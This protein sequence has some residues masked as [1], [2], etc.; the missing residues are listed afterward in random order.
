MNSAEARCLTSVQWCTAVVVLRCSLHASHNRKQYCVS[1]KDFLGT[2]SV[3]T[4]RTS[5][6]VFG[7]ANLQREE[8]L[9]GLKEDL[10]GGL[11]EE[12]VGELEE[13]LVGGLEEEL[14]GGLEGELVGR[15]WRSG[16]GLDER[17]EL[18]TALRGTFEVE[19]EA[20]L[21][22]ASVLLSA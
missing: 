4:L 8:L 2:P 12:L 20:L 9:V 1:S 19:P 15:S 22:A 18:E 21:E 17:E 11:E 14:V 6:S 16:H 3:L 5:S 10:V 13:D 7:S